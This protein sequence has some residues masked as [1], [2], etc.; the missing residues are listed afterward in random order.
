MHCQSCSLGGIPDPAA[1]H[2]TLLQPADSQGCSGGAGGSGW[3]KQYSKNGWRR[4][5]DHRQPDRGVWR[6]R[7]NIFV[8]VPCLARLKPWTWFIRCWL[9][10]SGC[11]IYNMLILVHYCFSSDSLDRQLN[12]PY[13]LRI[14]KQIEILFLKE[15]HWFIWSFI[16]LREGKDPYEEV[17]ITHK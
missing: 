17:T 7:I 3:T 5:R 11:K 10:S 16:S 14:N 12:A 13:H 9:I 2:S 15:K 1:G 6:W 4:G 8:L